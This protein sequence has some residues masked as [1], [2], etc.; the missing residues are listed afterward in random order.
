MAEGIISRKGGSAFTTNAVTRQASVSQGNTIAPGNIITLTQNSPTVSSF[1]LPTLTT[2]AYS[3][4]MVKLSETTAFVLY[5]PSGNNAA[6]IGAVITQQTNKTITMGTTST[7]TYAGGQGTAYGYDITRLNDGR[8]L[9]VGV[10]YN[11]SGWWSLVFRFI[12][13]SGTTVTFTSE[14]FGSQN[15]TTQIPQT[16]SQLDPVVLEVINDN[17]VLVYYVNQSGH[18]T[19]RIFTIS[20]T[21]ITGN[22]PFVLN[23][24]FS[25]QFLSIAKIDENRYAVGYQNSST[26]HPYVQIL[27][28]SGTAPNYDTV[29]M[30]TAYIPVT[31]NFRST[32][33][34]FYSHAGANRVVFAGWSDSA[35][36]A[37]L[38]WYD[39]SG[40]SLNMWTSAVMWGT[41]S[42]SQPA[43]I[44]G[45]A[46]IN[47]KHLYAD[48]VF[49]S[50]I[51]RDSSNFRTGAYRIY[52]SNSNVFNND[53]IA[54][55]TSSTGNDVQMPYA[56]YLNQNNV[57]LSMTFYNSSIN[58]TYRNVF[59]S[60]YNTDH[61][62]AANTTGFTVIR[63][64]ALTGGTQDQLIDVYTIGVNLT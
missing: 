9:Y 44:G 20:G 39:V 19:A 18:N 33:V 6:N 12:T 58:S 29:T 4:K 61:L 32:A 23:T 35:Y 45:N 31:E 49:V 48:R 54:Y 56:V 63:G 3:R 51:W 10:E 30:G 62:V 28:V 42:S 55:S 52:D 43:Y 22:T 46:N 25:T 8:I 38:Y 47:L 34:A 15:I 17:Q 14:I 50:G 37:R 5:G 36:R 26:N 41:S 64:F 24:T 16:Q 7:F 40:A 60:I 57:I 2:A 13:I 53:Y 1:D 27:V 21:T 59:Y 11:P